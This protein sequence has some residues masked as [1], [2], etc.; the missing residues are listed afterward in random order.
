MNSKIKLKGKMLT[1]LLYPIVLGLMA[2]CVGV[3]VYVHNMIA[4]LII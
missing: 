1:H 3:Y 4:G 2:V